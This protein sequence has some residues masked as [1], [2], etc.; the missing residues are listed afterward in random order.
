MSK[1]KSKKY[2]ESS[3]IADLKLDH[4][5]DVKRA[6]HAWLMAKDRSYREISEAAR[7]RNLRRVANLAVT[8]ES[9]DCLAEI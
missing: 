5:S 6:L 4:F 2:A 1:P 9:G 8:E 7:D 3:G